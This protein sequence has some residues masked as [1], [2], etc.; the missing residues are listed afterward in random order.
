MNSFL[1]EQSPDRGT[2]PTEDASVS[3][4]LASDSTSSTLPP[5]FMR[6]IILVIFVPANI[7]R[8]DGDS[9]TRSH[10]EKPSSFSGIKSSIMTSLGDIFSSGSKSGKGKR[11]VEFTAGKTVRLQFLFLPRVRLTG[12]DL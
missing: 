9:I 5:H 8:E 4:D 6:C 3:E 2:S 10:G 11:D 1:G 7:D 12:D